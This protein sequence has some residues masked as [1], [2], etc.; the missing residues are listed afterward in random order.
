MEDLDDKYR[1]ITSSL[2]DEYECLNCGS[3]VINRV[4]HEEF[5][6]RIKE[7]YHWSHGYEGVACTEYD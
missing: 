3:L 2:E 1:P 7:H 6:R 5:H 4:A